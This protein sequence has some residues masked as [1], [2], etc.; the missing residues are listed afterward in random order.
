MQLR[1]EF[2]LLDLLRF[3]AALCVLAFHFEIFALKDAAGAQRHLNG[4]DAAVDFFFILSGF[5]IAHSSAN[6]MSSLRDYG[7]FLARRLARIYPLHLLTFGLAVS[8]ALAAAALGLRLGTPERYAAAYIPANL[9]LIQ[10]WGVSDR[11][12]FNIVSWSISAEWFLYLTFPL[13]LWLARTLKFRFSI[14]VLIVWFIAIR[15]LEQRFGL[16]PWNDRTYQFA[17]IRAVPTFFLGIALWMVWKDHLS[18]RTCPTAITYALSAGALALMWVRVPGELLIVAFA[19]VILTGA[20]VP[21][22]TATSAGDSLSRLLGNASY[23]LYMWHHLI[24]TILFALL[25]PRGATMTAAVVFG[26]TA[27]SVIVSILSFQLFES[28]I[29]R[30][31]L[32]ALARLPGTGTTPSKKPQ[33]Q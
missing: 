5:V 26:A 9:L 27:A 12:S 29:K 22:A 4:F 20:M 3:L 8:L 17:M 18:E 31:I 2:V 30:V 24:G 25:N 16:V 1:R 21:S 7:Q 28:P 13:W 23:G 14:A 6:R 19:A 11:L 32:N 33:E 10:A 15:F